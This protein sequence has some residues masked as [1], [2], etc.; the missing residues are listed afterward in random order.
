MQTLIV[1]RSPTGIV[2]VTLHRP[3]KKNAIDGPMWDEL[4]AVFRE[5]A[6]SASDRVLV[7]TG[8]RFCAA[9]TSRPGETR[10]RSTACTT[11]AGSASR[12]TR[13]RSRPLRR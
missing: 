12:C 5:V 8:P 10:H 13:S 2:T 9:P 6:E 11:S 1:D 4:M 7:L 3:E